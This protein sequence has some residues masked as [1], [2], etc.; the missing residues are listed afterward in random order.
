MKK[1]FVL[2]LLIIPTLVF[3]SFPS[4]SKEKKVI[5]MV[6]ESGI[7]KIETFPN[8]APKTVSRVIE[9]ANSGFYDGLTFHRVIDG[10]MAQGGDPN[11]NGTGGSGKSIKAEFNDLKHERGIVSMARSQDPDSADSQFFIC[12]DEHPFL[13]GKYTIWGKVIEGMNLIDRI[14]SAKG[15]NGQVLNNHN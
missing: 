13:D 6:L 10:F 12:Y 9:L 8:K 11:G 1:Y 15:Q 2:L 14:P 3:F 7:V 4:F 5:F